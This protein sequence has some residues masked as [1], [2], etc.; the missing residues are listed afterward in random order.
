MF[1]TLADPKPDAILALMSMF[2]EDKRDYKLDLGV[3]IYKD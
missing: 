1:D 3:G 2:R